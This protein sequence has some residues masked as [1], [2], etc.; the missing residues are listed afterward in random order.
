MKRYVPLLVA[1][2]VVALAVP[3]FATGNGA[4]SGAHYTLNIIGVKNAKTAPMDD[5]NRHTIFVPL[6][7]SARIMLTEGDFQVLDGNAFDGT[8]AFQLPNPIP[9]NIPPEDYLDPSVTITTTYSVYVRALGKVGGKATV[10]P[11]I[12]YDDGETWLSAGSVTVERAKGKSTFDNCTREL[13]FV[14]YDIDGDET[15]ERVPLFSDDSYEYFWQYDNTGLKHAQ[16]RFYEIG[17]EVSGI[18]TK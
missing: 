11:G 5:S 16:F 15:I 9:E 18:P 8:A 17:T 14:Y 3:A 2:L 4:P 10:T 7:G 6:T 12:I 13:L 1:L